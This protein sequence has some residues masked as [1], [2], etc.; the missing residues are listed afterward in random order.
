LTCTNQSLQVAEWHS[1]KASKIYNRLVFSTNLGNNSLENCIMEGKT[2]IRQ[3]CILNL[4]NQLFSTNCIRRWFLTIKEVKSSK[5]YF[6]CTS[7]FL[8]GFF[9]TKKLDM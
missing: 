8:K 4:F 7:Y 9:V 1:I 2:F 5:S 3:K 6:C